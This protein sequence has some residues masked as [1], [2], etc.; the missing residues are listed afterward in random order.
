MCPLMSFIFCLSNNAAFAVYWTFSSILM[1]AVNFILNKKYP[2]M[3]PVQEDVK[4]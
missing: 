3:E 1:I 2:R 4:K